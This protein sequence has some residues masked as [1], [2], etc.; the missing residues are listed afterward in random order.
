MYV[1]IYVCIYIERERDVPPKNY[2]IYSA[3]ENNC[4]QKQ[5]RSKTI[6]PNNN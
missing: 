3:L 1:C 5:L 4:A 2:D 6:A